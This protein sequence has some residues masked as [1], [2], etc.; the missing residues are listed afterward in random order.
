MVTYMLSFAVA[1][2]PNIWIACLGHRP[3]YRRLPRW[4]DP[5]RPRPTWRSPMITCPRQPPQGCVPS[6]E[7]KE[8][9][10]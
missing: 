8:Q 5:T 2:T 9:G 10:P 1:T 3:P 7:L 6:E 4:A